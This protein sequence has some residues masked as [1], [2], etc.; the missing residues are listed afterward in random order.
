MNSVLPTAA[1]APKITPKAGLYLPYHPNLLPLPCIRHKWDSAIA[2]APTLYRSCL[3][4]VHPR[5]SPVF[6][7]RATPALPPTALT[8]I[9][10]ATPSQPLTGCSVEEKNVLFSITLPMS[11]HHAS[12]TNHSPPVPTGR[13]SSALPQLPL[14]APAGNA[15]A[16]E[17]TSQLL[18]ELSARCALTNQKC[19]G[20]ARLV[21]VEPGWGLRRGKPTAPGRLSERRS[22]GS[23]G[24][25]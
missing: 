8:P 17:R 20:S 15:P 13:C 14:A 21:C 16:G 6:T 12:P 10:T 24:L 9:H 4:N 19:T 2:I 7:G 18:P 1:A 3:G 11:R 22:S 23:A 5:P 25:A